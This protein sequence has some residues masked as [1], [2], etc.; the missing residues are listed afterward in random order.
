M[1][2]CSEE[3][4]GKRRKLESPVPRE[5]SLEDFCLALPKIE[6][7]AHLG[8][9]VRNGTLRQLLVEQGDDAET[10]SRKACLCQIRG[11]D[12]E[13]T[14]Q[15]QFEMFRIVH[16]ATQPL[17]A[18]RRIARE[19][20]EDQQA[21]GV[22]YAELRTTGSSK[23]KLEAVLRGIRDYKQ[24]GGSTDVKL[25][26]SVD[27]SRDMAAAEL[28]LRCAGE[29]KAQGCDE[30]VGMDFCGP[31]EGHPFTP[32]HA[33]LFNRARRQHDLR[34]T[35]HFAERQGEP[36]LAEIIKARPDRIGHACF[37]R[38][39]STWV[40]Q[41]VYSSGVPI[42]CCVSSNINTLQLHKGAVDHPELPQWLARRH[43]VL[44]AT[45]NPSLLTTTLSAQYQQVAEAFALSHGDVWHLAQ[46][47]V[48]HI[49]ADASYKQQLRRL[50]E[51]HPLNPVRKPTTV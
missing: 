29:L 26:V 1:A 27:R 42:E 50:Y 38:E 7:H 40:R 6:L 45:D 31:P 24:A 11:V 14:P 35:C 15:Q 47:C 10:A 5:M 9:S 43:P 21:D 16:S 34:L 13:R 2:D 49:F 18:K 33:R 28:A 51:H 3:K 19:F 23:A 22:V 8:G 46:G 17:S 12:T 41:Q 39:A 30:I 32:D 20:C 37:L 25:L 4:S 36:D 44:L 48:D